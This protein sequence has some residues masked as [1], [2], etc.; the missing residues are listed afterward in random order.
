[1]LRFTKLDQMNM[2]RLRRV[3]THRFTTAPNVMPWVSRM[4]SSVWTKPLSTSW[5]MDPAS[6][7]T[8]P[9]AWS[10]RLSFPDAQHFSDCVL[11]IVQS[12]SAF[13]STDTTPYIPVLLLTEV[14]APFPCIIKLIVRRDHFQLCSLSLKP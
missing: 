9:C 12:L 6:Y 10:L 4:C 7:S 13:M 1:M 8:I 11:V 14:H 3:H 5:L 2:K